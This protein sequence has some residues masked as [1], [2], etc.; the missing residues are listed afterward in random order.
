MRCNY[1]GSEWNVSSGLSVS[2][3]NCPF[4]GKSLL[5]EKKQ[6][7]TVE[8]VLVEI[9]RLFGVSVLADETKLVA[10]FSDLAPQ[11][12][13]Q[14]RILGYF[15]ECGGP[16]KIVSALN[17]SDDEQS[18]CI[19]QI[20][21][22]MKDEMYIEE[23]ASQMIC[24]SF[25]FAVSGR[26]ISE[27][28]TVSA[29]KVHVVPVNLATSSQGGKGDM[30]AEEQYL[31]GE[32]YFNDVKS[33]NSISKDYSKAFEWYQKAALRGHPLA[34][35][36]LGLLYREGHGIP[37]DEKQ[38]FD[39][40]MKAAQVNQ[41]CPRGKFYVGYSYHHGNG[42]Q[43]DYKE[44]VKWY[45]LA[46]QQS[47]VYAQ[48]NLGYCYEWGEGV[49]TD[50]QK[51]AYWYELSASQGEPLAKC[52][53]GLL[54]K[55][56]KGMQKDLSKAVSLF[57]ESANQG[58][59]CGILQLG[60]CYLEGTGVAKD[61]VQAF[62]LLKKAAALGEAVAQFK[63]AEGYKNGTWESKDCVQAFKWYKKAAEQGL[64]SAQLMI[65]LYYEE[66]CGVTQNYSEA[67]YWYQKAADQGDGKAMTLLGSCYEDGRGVV[68]NDI[69]ALA[70][71]ERAAKK[72]E[73]T[74][75]ICLLGLYTMKDCLDENQCKKLKEII[76]NL[77][78]KMDPILAKH[79]FFVAKE[80]I[81][82]TSTKSTGL[83]ILQL[84]AKDENLDT[85]LVNLAQL[86]IQE[87]LDAA[88]LVSLDKSASSYS[89]KK[90]ADQDKKILLEN[91]G[92]KEL[93]ET[94]VNTLVKK[95]HL[96]DIYFVKGTT[97]FNKKIMGAINAYAVSALSENPLL[98]Y[99]TTVFGSAKKGFILTSKELFYNNGFLGGRAQYSIANIESV[100][101]YFGRANLINLKVYKSAIN[102]TGKNIC[103]SY[104]ED[105]NEAARIEAFWKD[106]LQL[107]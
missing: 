48:L 45:T 16:R 53:L 20:V 102:D 35:C 42:V 82:Y 89:N 14:R 85:Q 58:E 55:R 100:S 54:Y 97:E 105:K 65:G 51:A 63:L 73:S 24:E 21:R 49:S 95:Y 71:Y 7:N 92:T 46:A 28:P 67:V 61:T 19:K 103:I 59:A 68:P 40:F 2:I 47:D 4:C 88:S 23:A 52:N 78:S 62:S 90:D 107:N 43:K 22:E 96:E 98:L 86:L 5:P 9:K 15:V 50:Y 13:R 10:Y 72:G 32:G 6:L 101:T 38:A 12:S 11:L 66:G 99:D 81:K 94:R 74:G 26:R 31:K 75:L 36:Q 17:A 27:I 25:L 104:T 18:V 84:C 93:S 56:G 29:P 8:D 37:K 39:W 91:L 30:T 80:M 1:C 70:W 3:T 87:E 44:A 33:G 60:I 79:G 76:D 41:N 64:S 77:D 83:N 57:R 106:L 34:Q 69:Q